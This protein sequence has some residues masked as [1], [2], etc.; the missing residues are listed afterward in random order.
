ME[1]CTVKLNV[2]LRSCLTFG[3]SRGRRN[4][5]IMDRSMRVDEAGMEGWI[6]AARAGELPEQ[7]W[8]ELYFQSVHDDSVRL[9]N[10]YDE[11]VCAVCSVS[12]C[13][14]QLG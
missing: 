11:R 4:R 6:C 8:C 5:I 7:L 9:R 1:G 14:G 3:R 2:H 13:R 10:A 12:I